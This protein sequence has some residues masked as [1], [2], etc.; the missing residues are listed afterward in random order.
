M[1]KN[2]VQLS[3][4]FYPMEFY[5]PGVETEKPR[6][7][8]LWKHQSVGHRLWKAGSIGAIV[9]AFTSAIACY[10]YDYPPLKVTDGY[11]TA[12]WQCAK[13]TG[14]VGFAFG[15]ASLAYQGTVEAVNA[16]QE[17][18]TAAGTFLGGLV[19]CMT[20]GMASTYQLPVNMSSKDEKRIVRVFVCEGF[21]Y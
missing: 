12:A 13:I 8:N 6:E 15:A 16:Y 3:R 17:R 14:K 18:R 10:W 20:L 7:E 2:L 21:L 19:G 4:R 5:R 1:D 9:G 11:R